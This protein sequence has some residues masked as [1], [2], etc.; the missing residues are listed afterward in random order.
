MFYLCFGVLFY[1]F[2]GT[3]I[4]KRCHS[5]SSYFLLFL[6]SEILH[7]KYSRNW[8]G[9]KPEIIYLPCQHR[10]PR[11]SRRRTPG[12]PHLP[13]A[14]P[15]AG[16]RL[17]MVRA[18]W[19]ATDLASPPIYCATR[20]NPKYPNTIPRKAPTEPS[21][22]T[23]VREGSEALPGTLPEGQIIAGGIYIAMPASEVMCE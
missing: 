13:Q 22:S 7:R 3:N 6:V 10:R 1:T 16:P 20:E 15:R 12:R 23:L 11:G 9:Q 17:G 21:S 8:T 19:A 5:V 2:S 14:R 4:L 18:P